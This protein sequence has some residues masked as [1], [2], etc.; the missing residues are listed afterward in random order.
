MEVTVYEDPACAWC[1]AFQPISTTLAFEFGSCVRPR[2]VMGGLRDLPVV[3]TR[4]Q[5][6]QWKQAE[7]VSGM[8]F[9]V[10]VWKRHDLKT[11]F[12]A[13]RAVKAA[14]M[15][16][17]RAAERLIRR[18]REAQFVER[19]PIDDV[20]TILRLGEE[21]GID[22]ETLRD[23]LASGRAETLFAR[24]RAEA[25]Q[26]GFGFP[27]I[28]IRDGRLEE[29]IVLQGVVP[30]SDIV[31]A[32]QVLDVGAEQRRQFHDTREDWVALFKIHARLTWA[33]IQ[34]VTRIE[35]SRLQSK[36]EAEGVVRDGV[37]YR[38]EGTGS[39][40]RG[41]AST[42]PSA[43]R[44]AAPPAQEGD[45]ASDPGATD[46]ETEEDEAKQA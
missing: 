19:T 4:F 25:A 8:P 6:R 37:F 10:R 7:A 33:E 20:E 21:V 13:C 30:Y 3:D 23:N 31:R 42:R 39:P 17:E 43:G 24:D 28:L 46:V 11:T 32:L 18:L 14:A 9:D 40:L 26:Y 29:P 12:T 45:A 35:R 1:W 16:Q 2:R 34:R 27:T 15:I 36:L 22:R 44:A 5:A 38:L 41:P